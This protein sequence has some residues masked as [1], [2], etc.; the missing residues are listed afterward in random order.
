[1]EVPNTTRRWH[2]IIIGLFV[3]GVLLSI[4]H[5]IWLLQPSVTATWLFYVPIYFLW[6]I[7]LIILSATGRLN[8]KVNNIALVVSALITQGVVGYV[9]I[10]FF[11]LSVGTEPKCTQ[12]ASGATVTYTCQSQSVFTP[13]DC[14]PYITHYEFV[15]LQGLGVV[16]K[17]KE[18]SILGKCE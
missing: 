15:G 14:A 16:V 1:M 13:L 2:R 12:V 6:L 9:L 18:E 4:W 10:V 8:L 3:I 17:T 7:A 5:P 11:A